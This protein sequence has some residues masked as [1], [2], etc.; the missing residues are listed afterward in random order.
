[1]LPIYVL[2][3]WRLDRRPGAAAHA[4]R[5]LEHR[6]G[7]AHGR[8]DA[9]AR[10]VGAMSRCAQ[11]ENGSATLDAMPARRLV[12][13]SESALAGLSV[14]LSRGDDLTGGARGRSSQRGYSLLEVIVAFA[15][16][17]VALS[18]LLGALSGGTR[19]VRWAADSAR[20]VLHAQSLLDEVG[21]GEVLAPGQRDGEFGGGRYRW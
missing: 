17:G 5:G 12:L 9:A 6:R 21:V 18:L 11:Q 15:V 20:A 4:R 2:Q 10:G 8:G 3:R 16:L 13:G 14:G 19:Q 1:A 7:L